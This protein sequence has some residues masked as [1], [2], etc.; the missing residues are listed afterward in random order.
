MSATR[1]SELELLA[2]PRGDGIPAFYHQT[3][4][5]AQRLSRGQPHLAREL[6]LHP[7]EREPQPQHLSPVGCGA[8][9]RKDGLRA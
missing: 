9:R 3:K 8:Q 5:L 4:P 2:H 1:Q 7:R 6:V